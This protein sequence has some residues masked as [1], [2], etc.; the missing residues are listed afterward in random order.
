VRAARLIEAG[1]DE[2]LRVDTLDAPVATGD[3]VL[4]EVEACGVCHRD[5]IDREG[6]FPFL[7]LPRT[8][9]HEAVGRVVGVGPDVT[10]W[11]IG[12]RI[13]TMHRDFCGQCVACQEGNISLCDQAASVLGL[14]IDGGY[15][16]H[17]LAPER[18][19]YR[20]DPDMSAAGAAMLHCTYGTAYRALTFAGEL[21][22]GQRVLVT[23]ANGGVGTAAIQVATRLGAAV[24]A[25][26]R[27]AQYVA[28]LKELGAS[29][30]LV[31]T[32]GRF[33]KQLDEAVDVV[34]DNVGQPTLNAALRCLKVGGRLVCV[35]NVVPERFPV[36]V[37]Y[38]ITYGISIRGNSGATRN[39]MAAVIALH[40]EQP[41][42]FQV[43]ACRPLEEADAAQREVKAGGLRG[44][45]VIAPSPSP[46]RAWPA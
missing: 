13:A 23:G 27:D 24:V 36:N 43:H 40:R 1:W 3:Q 4:V 11:A 10:E 7:S 8:P 41:F 33:H 6:R 45:I 22:S 17:V 25:V 2:D 12:D 19:W 14:V 42:A 20:A 26:V 46:G 21:R 44:R 37:G 30:V 35:G 38:L 16:T 29:E 18:C 9:G 34:V 32:D 15:A 5:L 31:N 28:W 39:D